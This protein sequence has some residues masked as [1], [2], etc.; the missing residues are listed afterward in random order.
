MYAT[1][2]KHRIINLTAVN[3]PDNEIKLNK[4]SKTKDYNT[5]ITRSN[6]NLEKDQLVVEFAF[7]L[8]YYIEEYLYT[9][10]FRIGEIRN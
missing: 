3:C 10:L 9:T 2:F 4:Y 5:L 8:T 6:S 1:I 7:A